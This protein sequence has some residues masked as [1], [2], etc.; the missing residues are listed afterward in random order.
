MRNAIPPDGS[1]RRHTSPARTSPTRVAPAAAPEVAPTPPASPEASAASSHIQPPPPPHVRPQ[2]GLQSD[3][4][5]SGSNSGEGPDGMGGPGRAPAAPWT[6]GAQTGPPMAPDPAALRLERTYAMEDRK[7]EELSTRIPQSR[8]NGFKLM[9]PHLREAIAQSQAMFPPNIR[10]AVMDPKEHSVV[11]HEDP[12][13]RRLVPGGRSIGNEG[14]VQVPGDVTRPTAR[15]LVH[16]HP[17]TGRHAHD[18]PSMADQLLA[19][20]LPDVE[21][22]VQTPAANPDKPNKYRIYTGAYPP[23]FHTLVENPLDLPASP[24]SSDDESEPPFKPH[25]FK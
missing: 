4:Y 14:H 8:P 25:P 22:I 15:I 19:R 20:E 17:Y 16:S 23:R 21:H 3:G 5:A 11:F 1:P 18:F 7:Y 24:H 10:G 2:G 13:T 6:S 9:T 12:R